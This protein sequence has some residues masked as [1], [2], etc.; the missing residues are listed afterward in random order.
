MSTP[1]PDDEPFAG[2]ATPYYVWSAPWEMSDE[3]AAFL[4]R[5]LGAEPG[6]PG[7]LNHEPKLIPL[8]DCGL[9][10]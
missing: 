4:Q 3:D 6:A 8:A 7:R 10:R 9:V 1:E 5:L 2:H